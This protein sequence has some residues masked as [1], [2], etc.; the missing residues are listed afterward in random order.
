MSVVAGNVS[1]W[2]QL[3]SGH[4]IPATRAQV[5]GVVEG[6]VLT[7]T[8]TDA[9][10]VLDGFD[11]SFQFGPA[12]FGRTSDPPQPGDRCLVTFIGRGMDKPWLLVWAAPE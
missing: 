7:V 2:E 1:G 3:L 6:R 10:F 11:P 4:A 5:E 9:Y 8:D 12:P